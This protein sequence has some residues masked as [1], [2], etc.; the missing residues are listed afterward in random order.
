MMTNKNKY[1][2]I[3]NGRECN[4]MIENLK[5]QEHFYQKEL[6]NN[7]DNIT[8]DFST[9]LKNFALELGGSMLLNLAS[10]LFSKK[11]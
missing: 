10:N 8:N 11:K 7:F 9:Q 4:L 5:N 6:G 2:K 3:K 1:K